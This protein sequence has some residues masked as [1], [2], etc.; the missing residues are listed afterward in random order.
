MS[1]K[2]AEAEI[3]AKG[4]NTLASI[5]EDYTALSDAVALSAPGIICE[6]EGEVITVHDASDRPLAGLRVFGRSAQDGVP[7]PEAPVEIVSLPAPVV[8]VSDATDDNV[9]TL[10]ISTSPTL[11]G[12]PVPSGGNHTDAGGQQWFCDEI[13]FAR[14]VYVQR[15][16]VVTGFAKAATLGDTTL[17]QKKCADILCGY[18]TKRTMCNYLD[19]YKYN[20]DDMPHYYVENN[21]V[22][23]YLPVGVDATDVVVLACWETPKEIPLSDADKLA[24][25]ALHSNK[26]TTVIRNDAGA[27]MAVEYVADTKLYIDNALA[28]LR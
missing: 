3:E 19:V 17:W 28:A 24:F 22:N 23:L 20:T 12:V 1:I 26:P 10:A 14:G 15:V 4:A 5:P 7:T 9:Q 18:I 21:S 16:A 11:P 2:V 27:W 25:R 6:A 8:T 13:D